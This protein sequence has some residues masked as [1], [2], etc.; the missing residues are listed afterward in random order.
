MKIHNTVFHSRG[1]GGGGGR[2]VRVRNQQ[3]IGE[4]QN[5]QQDNALCSRQHGYVK[6]TN[7]MFQTVQC[8]KMQDIHKE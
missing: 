6:G 2:N 4:D 5:V 7:P 1:N 3:R 8:R